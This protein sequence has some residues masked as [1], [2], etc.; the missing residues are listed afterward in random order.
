[1]YGVAGLDMTRAHQIKRSNYS[2]VS[3]S[4]RHDAFANSLTTSMDTYAPSQEEELQN[5]CRR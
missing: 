2:H 5:T 4:I 1:M 3:P